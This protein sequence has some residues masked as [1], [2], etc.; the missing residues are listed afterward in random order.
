MTAQ[1]IGRNDLWDIVFAQGTDQEGLGGVGVSLS[2]EK[3]INHKTVLVDCSPEPVADAIDVHAYL[4]QGPPRIPPW[5]PVAT[6]FREEGTDLKT[7]VTERLVA[8][9]T[10][11]LGK[12]FLNLT[13]A[14][15][16]AVV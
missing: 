6:F 11:S 2:L 5:F 9:L 13:L 10:A 8:D 15:G 16:K 14:Q 12:Q 3:K 4:V 7:P 1:L